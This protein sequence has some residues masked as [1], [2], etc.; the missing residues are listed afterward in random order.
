MTAFASR[1]HVAA[2]LALMGALAFILVTATLQQ[3]PPTLDERAAA[4][5]RQLRCPTCQGL[6]VADSPATSA[7]QIRVVVREQ[8]AAG[9][10]DDEVRAYFVA[11]YGRWI[12]LDPPLAGLDLL[13]WLAPGAVV[14]AGAIVAVARARA[15]ARAVPSRRWTLAS[16]LASRTGGAAI[17]IVMVAAL[18]APIAVA[19]VP[20]L[21]G[22]E[23]TGRPAAAPASLAELEAAARARPN[24]PEPQLALAEALL[25]A[26]RPEDAAPWFRATLALDP[27]SVRALLGL[28][29]ILLEAGRPDGAYAAFDRV[30]QLDP[31][32]PDAL[33]FRAVSQLNLAGAITADVRAD[34]ESFLR[35]APQSDA[36][37]SMAAS[38]LEGTT[39][40]PPPP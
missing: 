16:P 11:R 28:G 6:S 5:D 25:D 7:A 32:Q 19:V 10:S 4:L 20:R 21:V 3:A 40:S 1:R 35:V 31:A 22:Q 39:A 23:A 18:A 34:L 37:R 9:A 26:D 36:R 14:I 13:L 15:R 8:L 27:S 33:L 30:L 29:A 38:L 2:G 24:D 17:A 12:L